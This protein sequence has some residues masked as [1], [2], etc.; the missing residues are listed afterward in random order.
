[1]C[2]NS[3]LRCTLTPSLPCHFKTTTK[4]AKFETLNCFCLLLFLHWDV[5]GVSSKHT[6]LKVDVIGPQNIL[7][8]G[9][10]VHLSARNFTGWGSEG[11]N[12]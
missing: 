9:A 8:A 7:F 11:V 4:R 12:V 1:M 6:A 3:V 2:N 5:K 10:S